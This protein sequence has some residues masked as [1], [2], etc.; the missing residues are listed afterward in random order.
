M[1]GFAEAV[2]GGAR[3]AVTGEGCEWTALDYVA[4]KHPHVL[5]RVRQLNI[6]LHFAP[7]LGMASLHDAD[8]V[9]STVQL[10]ELHDFRPW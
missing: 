4:R 2:V 7:G 8:K 6:E 1:R 3:G 10:L 9:L 5:S